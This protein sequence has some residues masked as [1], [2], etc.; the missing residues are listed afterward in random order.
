VPV[1]WLWAMLHGMW[2][3]GIALGLVAIVGI[4]LDGWPRLREQRGVLLRLLAVPALSLVVVGLTPVGPGLYSAV[5][6]VS[7]RSQFHDEWAPTNFH[8]SQPATVAA[9]IVVT[10]VVWLRVRR[11]TG[12]TWVEILVLLMAA[13]WSAYAVR[14]VP[15]AAMML[16]P[17]LAAALQSLI[18]AR[19]SGVR[20]ERVVVGGLA[21]LAVVAL[22]ALVPVTSNEP[23]AVPAW[24]DPAL[25]ALPAGTAVQSIGPMGGYLM[26][27][28]PRLDPVIDGYTDAYTTRHLKDEQVLVAT[29]PGWDRILKRTGP[30]YALLPIRS[31]LTYG[32]T[33]FEGWET[34]HKSKDVVLLEAPEGWDQ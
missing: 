15:I 2:P 30:R 8:M 26:W 3:I 34:L 31:S 18:G 20:R 21:A 17:L 4:A 11:G 12:T 6:L 33:Q 28:Y 23:A 22:T 32:L 24:L 10:L 13:G 7:G 14:T 25:D 27:R 9:V 16:V 5:L 19:R 1:T 29:K